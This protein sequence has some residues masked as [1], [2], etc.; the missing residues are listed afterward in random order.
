MD[1]FNF[2]LTRALITEIYNF[3]PNT[4]INIKFI[5]IKNQIY[6]P[7]E[8]QNTQSISTNVGINSTY[9][10]HIK[11]QPPINCLYEKYFG[12]KKGY[13]MYSAKEGIIDIICQ[14]HN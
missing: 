6:Y 8:F 11:M 7:L 10:K 2:K 4:Y 9:I 5:I 14:L 12:I 3:V 13:K 1:L